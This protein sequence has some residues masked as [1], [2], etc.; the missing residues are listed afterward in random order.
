MSTIDK[1]IVEMEFDNKQFEKGV[2]T[3]MDTL[4]KLNKK[5]ELSDGQ[6]GLTNISKAANSIKLDGL[7]S[8]IEALNKRFSAFGIA[9]MTVIKNLTEAGIQLGKNLWNNTIGQI[10]QGGRARA[11][12]IQQAKFMLEGLG[13]SWDE[14]SEDI[15][16]A[17]K[18]TAYGLDEAAM[19]C[20]Q[21][22]ASGIQ[23]KDDMKVA[24]GG[25][26]GLAAM[27][28]SD[29]SDIARI[30]TTVAGNGRLMG[31][32]LNQIGQ[33]G[34]NAA[35]TLGK[36]LNMTE[37]EVRDA[38]S[39]GAIDFKM[40]ANAMYD[41]FFKTAKGANKLTSG[42]IANLKAALS[43]LGEGF[44]TPWL[45]FIRDMALAVT[46]VIDA[47]KE[48]LVPGFGQFAEI[49]KLI[50]DRFTKFTTKIVDLKILDGYTKAI[51]SGLRVI[52]LVLMAVFD[53]WSKVFGGP[54]LQGVKD[55]GDYLGT[56]VTKFANFIS[57]GEG[58]KK[59][60]ETLTRIFT[61][62]K[63]IYEKVL[64]PVGKVIGG[65]IV[66]VGKLLSLIINLA[67]Y[68][69]HIT[70]PL[71]EI[72]ERFFALID[73]IQNSRTF[74]LL[75]TIFNN[76]V[77][78]AK[79]LW[80]QLKDLAVQF[81][82]LSSVQRI[83]KGL[84]NA[85]EWVKTKAGEAWTYIK[86]KFFEVLENLA[87]TDFSIDLSNI[88][89][90]SFDEGLNG[91]LD[92]L[93]EF[94]GKVVEKFEEIKE[95]IVEWFKGKSIVTIIS[96]KVEEI[97]QKLKTMK[98]QDFVDKLKDVKQKIIDFKDKVIEAYN[99]IKKALGANEKQTNDAFERFKEITGSEVD[100]SGS[101]IFKAGGAA[102]VG[103]LIYGLVQMFKGLKDASTNILA[104]KDALVQTM[105]AV[106]SCF[107]EMQKTIKAETIKK[108]AASVLMIAAAIAILAL[109]PLDRLA[110]GLGAVGAIG[111]ELWAFTK[112]MSKIKKDDLDS[113][114]KSCLMLA[115]A[116]WIIGLA[117]VSMGKLG[118]EG[119]MAGALSMAIVMVVM[120]GVI[121]ALA[122]LQ[123][124][125]KSVDIEALTEDMILLAISVVIMSIAVKSMGKLEPDQAKQGV[126]AVIAIM[127][128]IVAFSGAMMALKKYLGDLPMM[129]GFMLSLAVSM[130]VF[131]LAV[132][133]LGKLK[134][135]T[136]GQG[137]LGIAALLIVIGYFTAVVAAS[138]ANMLALGAGMMMFAL[139]MMALVIPVTILGKLKPETLGQGILA[140]VAMLGAFTLCA[141]LL[142]STGGAGALALMGIAVAM[143]IMAGAL[144]VL[145][146][147]IVPATL[148]I[149]A[150]TAA[151]LVLIVAGYLLAP[152]TVFILAA[153]AAMLVLGTGVLLAGVGFAAFGSGL[154]KTAMALKLL[155]T[156][157]AEAAEKIGT[158]LA[159]AIAGI[160]AGI[161]YL[162]KA[163]AI[164][165]VEGIAAFLKALADASLS[166]AE[167]LVVLGTNLLAVC[168]ALLPLL[169]DFIGFAI[170]QVLIV[171]AKYT[172]DVVQSVMNILI[173][174]LT[175]INNNIYQIVELVG[176]IM[177]NIARALIDYIPQL[178][179]ICMEMVVQM[180]QA[181]IAAL[182][183]YGPVFILAY[184][185]FWLVIGKLTLQLIEE[186]FGDLPIIGEKITEACENAKQSMTDSIADNNEQIEAARESAREIMEEYTVTMGSDEYKTKAGE[187]ADGV[188][189]QFIDT[190]YD[191][192][193]RVASVGDF[194]GTTFGTNVQ[195]GLTG[196]SGGM[197]QSVYD[198]YIKPMQDVKADADK[199]GNDASTAFATTAIN[200][201]GEYC[202]DM[203][204]GG[205]ELVGM[206]GDGAK[207]GNVDV[208]SMM[209]KLGGNDV[210]AFLDGAKEEGEIH[211]PSK[212]T[213]RLGK[214][215]GDGFVNGADKSKTAVKNAG[216][217][218][219]T[220]ALN[221]LKSKEGQ[222][223]TVG[224]N[225]SQG[226]ALGIR[227]M[228][229]SVSSAAASIGAIALRKLKAAIDSNSPS[230]ETMEIGKFFD[231]GF[232]VGIA[233][234]NRPV[235]QAVEN[236][237]TNAIDVMRDS[238][239]KLSS[240]M[241]MDLDNI[242]PT[243]SP[244]LDLNGIQAGMDG[245][246]SI[247]SR[248]QAVKANV[249]MSD[250][251]SREYSSSLI[252][253]SINDMIKKSNEN[254]NKS[255][256]AIKA[257]TEKVDSLEVR[258]DSGELVGGIVEKMDNAFGTR[259]MRQM[260]SN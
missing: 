39:K 146:L 205:E 61:V 134:P 73:K 100:V 51:S 215:L 202:P 96:E 251:K 201:I 234:Y 3:S 24:L 148:G 64:V 17:V 245:I 217:S 50:S 139:A 169:L 38:T 226:F 126:I 105:N 111:L 43:R 199:A 124:K 142:G 101:D 92:K 45:E 186:M 55:F 115:G 194:L 99:E 225:F 82:N 164:G 167:S 46:P 128:A 143:V 216:M 117:V 256:D 191:K 94:K 157:S 248:Q 233:K 135:E 77:S 166:I 159:A 67:V 173:A 103:G 153:A 198:N 219:A 237:G 212:A 83:I 204:A 70:P 222:S 180:I 154:L 104:V 141:K 87:G 59:L 206:L 57:H 76:L 210:E 72:K 85:F 110:K 140:V 75:S 230:K 174:I 62:M 149:I 26:S 78:A 228:I 253:G 127:G 84:G 203:K 229:S 63:E 144:T 188:T 5:L 23:L 168:Y 112:A 18:G 197:P 42:A 30:F 209:K 122:I 25:I 190:A 8:G 34:I 247:F 185:N 69:Y 88:D 54:N 74:Q 221:G 22:S 213:E 79:D 183:I 53:V 208:E 123:D 80:A 2:S 138:K 175:A 107:Q 200:K 35:A 10:Q 252:N 152:V 231:A 178:V 240:V 189:D 227:G 6:K 165:I 158:V 187:A 1:R 95:A 223:R 131:S 37:E 49:L 121:S 171:T 129:A 249:E 161:G 220:S 48:G 109:I 151:L 150:I 66:V 241:G 91:I 52:K 137:I 162:I 145:G 218:I 93:G 11:Q 12:N 108:I 133:I 90:S 235:D 118:W 20:S 130:V 31:D 21:L 65:I 14:A 176:C 81:Y 255:I 244:V 147:M 260:R 232:A 243:I 102:A 156:I 136:M 114:S 13:I 41:A 27:T 172:P 155:S 238:V 71:D 192:G 258:L 250:W 132:A 7:E 9:G 246:D 40:F 32:Q 181:F 36:Y 177:L 239:S 170:A 58:A 116:L 86:T 207:N 195:G 193:E 47:I 120:T 19:A 113:I 16:Y 60:R 236:L 259:T 15:N 211:S 160:A 28:G 98:F 196:A 184:K 163:I 89:L 97:K 254:S 179:I 33:R 125:F 224:S 257:L 29:F 242:Q 119:A 68:L 4:D 56:I 44:Q 182:D 106:T 214:N